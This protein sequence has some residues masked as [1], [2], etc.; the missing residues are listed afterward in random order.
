M[1]RE[2]EG[3][4]SMSELRFPWT[5]FGSRVPQNVRDSRALFDLEL[6]S[7]FGNLLSNANL[8][9]LFDQ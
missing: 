9:S 6:Y 3:K 8:C 4:I 5:E 7:H 2:E 1:K